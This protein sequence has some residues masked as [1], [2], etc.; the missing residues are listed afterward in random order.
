MNWL[1]DY[2]PI[3]NFIIDCEWY[4]QCGEATIYVKR[5]GEDGKGGYLMLNEEL[6]QCDYDYNIPPPCGTKEQPWYRL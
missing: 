3:L 1:S 5:C 4:I 6:A 2:A